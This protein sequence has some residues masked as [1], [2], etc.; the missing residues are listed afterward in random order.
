MSFLVGP[1]SY[2]LQVFLRGAEQ[3]KNE[4][5]QMIGNEIILYEDPTPSDLHFMSLN[6]F[7]FTSSTSET[8]SDA[9]STPP[10]LYSAIGQILSRMLNEVG[11]DLPSNWSPEE[12]CRLV[13]GDDQMLTP[14]YLADVYSNLLECNFH[15]CYWEVAFDYIPLL[16]GL[17]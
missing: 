11:A 14:S 8:M 9:Q 10:N 1:T 4:A 12:F 16:Y 3:S 17:T 15:S 6:T 2:F 13:I 5:N 7:S